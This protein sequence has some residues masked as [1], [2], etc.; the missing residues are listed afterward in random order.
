MSVMESL[1]NY[2]RCILGDRRIYES[3]VNKIEQRFDLRS[4]A[5]QIA[6]P[7]A[8]VIIKSWQKNKG[9][10]SAFVSYD[11]VDFLYT[12]E[13]SDNNFSLP[14]PV[15][16][17][18]DALP[19]IEF[20]ISVITSDSSDVD[21]DYVHS[22]D[23]NLEDEGL[24]DGIIKVPSD[25]RK[26]RSFLSTLHIE[27]RAALAHEM[28]H[29]VQKVIYGYP[30]DSVTNLDLEAHMNDP[31]EID[32]RVEENIAYLEDHISEDDLDQFIN[33]LGVYIEKY[34]KRNASTASSEELVVYRTRMMDSHTSRY[35]EKMGLKRVA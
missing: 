23:Q 14:I 25:P 8:S 34:L 10:L 16:E 27:L 15:G 31:M 28:Q 26:A 9:N 21:A 20:E 2:V 22:G 4:A 6:N 3:A 18:F 5:S 13:V 11:S 7:V 32:A 33:K 30:L 29:A 24:V 19:E 17:Y 35:I 12:D 1:R